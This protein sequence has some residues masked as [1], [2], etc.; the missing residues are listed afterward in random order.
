M[1]RSAFTVSPRPNVARSINT[2]GALPPR[3]PVILRLLT[4]RTNAALGSTAPAAADAAAAGGVEPAIAGTA[5]AAG[6]CGGVASFGASATGAE[7]AGAGAALEAAEGGVG[8]AVDVWPAARGVV[9]VEP[10]FCGLIGF[11]VS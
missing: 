4:Q 10:S 5:F 2:R 6:L 3:V 1:P 11:G 9:A 7:T 8:V